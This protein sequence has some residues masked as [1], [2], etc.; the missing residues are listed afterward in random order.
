MAATSDRRMKTLGS[1]AVG[2]GTTHV[3]TTLQPIREHPLT[4]KS[5]R[6]QMLVQRAP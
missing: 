5:T 1:F 2:P 4:S 6:L 3:D